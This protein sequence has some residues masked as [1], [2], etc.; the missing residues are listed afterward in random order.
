MRIGIA[1]GP[2]VVGE[3]AGVGEQSKLAIGSTPNL[4]A[5]LQGLASADQI[6]VASSTRRLVGNAFEL[7][8]L[9]EHDLKGIAEPVHAWRVTALSKAASRFEAATQGGVTPLVGREL[10]IE[11]LLDRWRQA[12]EGEGQVVLLSG[13][14][15]IGKSRVMSTLRERL[16]AQG[17]QAVRFQC[18]PYHINSAFYPSIDNF[19]RVLK[20]SRD[21]SPESKL[22]KLEA[23]IVKQFARPLTDVRFIASLLSIPCDERYGAITM[24]PQRFKDETLRTLVDLTEAAARKHPRVMLYEDAHWADPTSLEV[25]DLLI[26]RVKTFPLLIVLTHRPEFQPKWDSHGHVTAL[27]L[28]KLTRAQSGAIVDKLTQGKELPAGLLD[29]I[30]NKTDGVPLYVEELTKSILE[31]GELKAVGNHYDYAGAARS[32]TIPATLRDSLTARLDRS[33]AAKEIAQIGA[34]IGREFGYELIAA[35]APH[36]KTDLDSALNQL[37]ESGLAFRRGTPPEATYAFKHALV[38]D[39]AYDSLLKSRR[40]TLHAK[41]AQALER[42]VTDTTPEVLAHHFT[43]A[44]LNERAVPYWL[45]AGRRSLSRP[46]LPEAVSHLTTALTLNAQLSPSIQRDRQELSIRLALG[47]AYFALL[48]WVAIEVVQIL[49]PARELARR[50]GDNEKLLPI[51]YYVWMHYGMRCEYRKAFAA[52]DEI[53]EVGRAT[54][55]SKAVVTA[56]MARACARTWVGEFQDARRIGAELLHVYDFD[57]HSSLAQIYN[58]DPKCL[59]LVWAGL[60]L[61]ALGYPDQSREACLEQLSHA[62]RV[63]QPFNL[64]WG[65]S[66]GTMGLLLRGD[67]DLVRKWLE[68]IRHIGQ[69]QAMPIAELLQSWWGGYTSIAEGKYEQGYAELAPGIRHWRDTGGVHLVPYANM[70]LALALKAMGRVEEA[71]ILIDDALEVIENT[72]HRMHEAE[73]HRIKGELLLEGSLLSPGSATESFLKALGVARSQQAKG[74]ELRAAMSLARLWKSQGKRKDAYD[75]LAPVYNWFT[76]GFDTKD[77]IDA[78]ALLEELA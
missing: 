66:G 40:Q 28:S 15:G 52:A 27:N 16:T 63:G 69:E 56:H 50:L 58:H 24:T 43:Q 49:E 20:F 10:E 33:P 29:Q 42:N 57:R 53:A 23:L 31:S 1:T 34:A 7:S 8:D 45:A 41:I 70:N 39:A 54:A 48:G 68:E 5:R 61:W 17:A 2:V 71:V 37:T 26:D 4:A 51:L 65:L 67:T 72:G 21:E 22:D 9:G 73:V 18:S 76:E 74:W 32:V 47:T 11:L 14:P 3:Q 55:D 46:A 60:W 38:Q 12:Q 62:R 77:L 78:K 64:L 75:L 19:E 59:T 6:V 44:G 13:E 36:S 25:L 30:L 35:V